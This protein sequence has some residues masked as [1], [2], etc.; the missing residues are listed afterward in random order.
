[1]SATPE[2]RVAIVTGSESGIGRAIAV[3][4][5]RDGCDVGVVWFQSEEEGRA[6]VRAVEQAG[7]RAALEWLDLLRPGRPAEAV[8]ALTAA[9]GGVDVVVNCAG[10][11]A[12]GPAVA[13]TEADV[14]RV[15]DVNLVGAYLFTQ[16]AARHMIAAGRG[17]RIVNITSINAESVLPRGAAYTASK[18]GLL[19]LTKALALELAPHAITVN[20][21]APGGIAVTRTG[22]DENP[23]PAAIAR[24]HI[25]AGRFGLPDE[26]ARAVVHL[27]APESGYTTGATVRVDG[28]LSLTRAED[29]GPPLSEPRPL[30]RRAAARLRRRMGPRP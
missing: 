24:A 15:I 2:R 12:L 5:A 21:V 22:F 1:M 23:A 6:T 26:V 4:L 3:A 10:T 9:L 18:H 16:A 17:G 19:G 20:A 14:R 13:A 25:P 27:A 7:G 29:Q 11:N 28:G 8:D 30:H